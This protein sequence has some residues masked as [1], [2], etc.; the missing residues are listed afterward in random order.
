M[1]DKT[2]HIY[3]VPGLA[4]DKEIFENIKLPEITYTLHVISWLMP[5]K[6]E[7][8][9]Q[10]ARRMAGF[11]TEKNAILVGV[12][13]GGVV[14]QEMSSYLE[15][16]KLIIISSVKTKFELPIKFKIAKK[17][18]IYK[19]LP[20]R[21]LLTSKNYSRFVLG[22]ISRKRLKLYQDY[23]PI[24]DKYYLDW[25]IKNMI[26]WNQDK[27]L[28]GVFHI[29]GDNDLV[30]PIKNIDNVIT[31]TGGSHIMLLTKGPLVSRKIVDIISHN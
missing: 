26:C 25:A 11:V 2:I 27:P 31:V 23:L 12:S 8:I 6:K 7:T 22:P 4:A 10:Y 13:F 5:S 30:F 9:V 1:N 29:H 3:F 19:L 14:A 16:K 28:A 18:K 21:L 24:R 15:L 17:L 20:T